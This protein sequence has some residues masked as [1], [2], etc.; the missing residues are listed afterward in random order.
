MSATSNDHYYSAVPKSRRSLPA[1]DSQPTIFFQEQQGLSFGVLSNEAPC[2]IPRSLC[3]DSATYPSQ[4]TQPR[5]SPGRYEFNPQALL[6]PWS[7]SSSTQH[8][9]SYNYETERYS[10]QAA[11]TAY[12][13]RSS[14][15]YSGENS[16]SRKLPPLSSPSSASDRWTSPTPY[17]SS[18]QTYSGNVRSPASN[19]QTY[20]GYSASGSA[21]PYPYHTAQAQTTLT[22]PVSTS[23]ASYDDSSRSSNYGRTQKSV[24]PP[25]YIP[26]PVSPTS[27]PEP[28][29]KKKRKR[30][31][32]A[33]VKILNETFNRT[34][35]PSTAERAMLAERLEMSARSVQIWFQNKRQQKKMAERQSG[36]VSPTSSQVHPVSPGHAVPSAQPE[37]LSMASRSRYPGDHSSGMPA[38]P[39]YVQ[40]RGPTEMPR[41]QSS[42]QRRIRS[43]ADASDLKWSSSGY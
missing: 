41:P 7:A 36:N 30:A 11:Y 26:P 29:I 14:P 33:Q 40:Q 1:E 31:D 13:S 2:S 32:P 38:P 10:T 35:F 4:Y 42:S 27:P 22:H 39:I 21:T 34:Q 12:P 24:A 6:G 5:S 3:P 25:S 18:S 9:S 28:T 17:L 15:T 43:D 16:E 8:S 23:N 37:S 20:Q 19:Y